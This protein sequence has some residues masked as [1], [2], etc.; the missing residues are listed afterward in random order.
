[1]ER[2]AT[3]FKLHHWDQENHSL[4]DDDKVPYFLRSSK[5]TI[6]TEANDECKFWRRKDILVPGT[7]ISINPTVREVNFLEMAM[8]EEKETVRGLDFHV[9][10]ET[11]EQHVLEKVENT[12]RCIFISEILSESECDEL[13]EITS[14]LGYES[15]EK[16]YPKSY[17]NNERVLVISK[18]LANILWSRIRPYLKAQDFKG[19]RPY[20]FDNNG[21]WV[22]S[23]INECLRFNRYYKDKAFF[24][25]HQDAKF[26]KNDNEQSI[27][28]ILVYLGNSAARTTLLKKVSDSAEAQHDQDVSIMKFKEL[29][30]IRSLKGAAAIFNHDLYHEGSTVFHGHKHVLRT[31]LVF[32][33]IDSESIYRMN[34]KKDEQYLKIKKL[35]DESV[36]LE[37]QGKI[38]QS[39]IKYLQAH[40]LH[41]GQSHSIHTS[42]GSSE[43]F[44]ESLLPS[45]IFVAIFSFL[46]P[47]EI[48]KTV[49]Y[50]NRNMNAHARDPVLWKN[51]YTKQWPSL[52]TI[53]SAKPGIDK[54]SLNRP[55]TRTMQIVSTENQLIEKLESTS[56]EEDNYKDWYHIF[57]SRANM[58]AYFCPVI[59]DVGLAH[60][61]YGLAKNNSFWMSCSLLGKP[62][63]PHFYLPGYGFDDVLCGDRFLSSAFHCDKITLFSKNRRIRS[64]TNFSIFV[65]QLYKEDLQVNIKEHPIV[66]IT[67]PSWTE[68]DK[69][70]IKDHLFSIDVPAICFVD[71]CKMLAL[72]YQLET[73]LRIDIG[74]SGVTCTPVL[75][76]EAHNDISTHHMP[77]IYEHYL[78]AKKNRVFQST[79]NKFWPY[80]FSEFA[81]VP[82][83]SKLDNPKEYEE[84][85]VKTN[86]PTDTR[87][88]F[89]KFQQT[90][91]VAREQVELGEWYYFSVCDCVDTAIAKISSSFD[92]ATADNI[93]SNIL[94][95]GGGI[96]IYG[97]GE[98]LKR[99]I[100][101]TL[102]PSN[103]RVTFTTQASIRFPTISSDLRVKT[104]RHGG[105][106]DLVG[107]AKIF[108]S[109][110]N[111]K[112]Y[113]EFNPS[114][115]SSNLEE[116]H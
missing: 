52:V 104:S 2:S 86:K 41:T 63:H 29:A 15:L 1:M 42:K 70:T 91:Q 28:T 61:R 25:P 85:I 99:R 50:L 51:F 95:T 72:Y 100:V 5:T 36:Q 8:N 17:R 89:A 76:G 56:Q 37:K 23:Y 27:F 110:H 40:E 75:N 26:V 53:T 107:G 54:Y 106:M 32:R 59:L 115:E 93:F 60:Y 84:F 71:P 83:M 81:I 66:I 82:P 73:F 46:I 74:P 88:V 77:Q 92:K 58:E 79:T 114:L 21:T 87:S 48:C 113:C 20:G 19:V 31:E 116:S 34:Y 9:S 111:F 13:V 102:T 38:E 68:Q 6:P 11:T 16:E 44:I 105:D 18:K 57:I 14:Q 49:L 97:L 67:P 90:P 94:L 96:H 12:D 47:K 101:E 4:S 55:Q 112:H 24:K 3:H 69:E 65:Y 43:S 39:T 64:F 109:L 22:P 80:D 10:K 45:E 33:R 78:Q 62:N 103:V 30:S 7:T 108:T 98:R 35:I